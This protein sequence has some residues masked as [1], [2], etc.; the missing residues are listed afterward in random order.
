M[1]QLVLISISQCR[2]TRSTKTQ[3]QGTQSINRV[4]YKYSRII[5]DDP[6]TVLSIDR[7]IPGF[8]HTVEV[9]LFGNGNVAPEAYAPQIPFLWHIPK[10]SK[11]IEISILDARC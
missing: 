9:T 1:Q 11:E 8:Q 7:L 10:N 2:S 5:I 6:S 3:Y 4:A